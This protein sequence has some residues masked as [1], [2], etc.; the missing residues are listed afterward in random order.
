MRLDTYHVYIRVLLWCVFVYKLL[1]RK[2]MYTLE[3]CCVTAL[4]FLWRLSVPVK[5]NHVIVLFN[6]EIILQEHTRTGTE[7]EK[8]KKTFSMGFDQFQTL[9]SYRNQE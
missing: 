1:L 3:R 6:R 9:Q 7:M 4:Q 5:K 8:N 2:T